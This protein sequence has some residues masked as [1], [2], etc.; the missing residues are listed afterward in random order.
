MQKKK[1]SAFFVCKHE[2]TRIVQQRHVFLDCLV[3]GIWTHAGRN[4]DVCTPC[5][6]LWPQWS[7]LYPSP[8]PLCPSVPPPD[9]S[10]GWD[11]FKWLKLSSAIACM[12]LVLRWTVY[13]TVMYLFFFFLKES[14]SSLETR[15]LLAD[16]LYCKASVPPTDKVCLWLGVSQCHCHSFLGWHLVRQC[17]FPNMAVLERSTWPWTEWRGSIAGD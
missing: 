5:A 7:F 14:T 10:V 16:N 1:V 12:T 11:C 6:V 3:S 4:Q 8:L 17:V 13:S 15:F 2:Q 9:L